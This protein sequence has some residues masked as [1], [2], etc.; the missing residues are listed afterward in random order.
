MKENASERG[1]EDPS[2][3]SVDPARP[4]DG[5][6]RL[7]ERLY[8]CSQAGRWQLAPEQFAAA[9]DG[10]AGG[11]G[12]KRSLFRYFHGR[13]SLKTWLRAVLAQRHIDSI[14]A[15]RRFEE[16]A[17]DEAPSERR[18]T[19]PGPQLPLADP[20]RRHYLTLF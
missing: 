10:L 17:D 12:S 20:H 9:L 3:D 4:L 14:R 5:C 6:A 2:K 11:K 13:S 1:G 8:G 16:L 18:N 15:G 7:V 19:V